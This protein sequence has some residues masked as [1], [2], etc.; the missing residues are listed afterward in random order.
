[1]D[2]DAEYVITPDASYAAANFGSSMARLGDFTGDNVDD[3]AIGVPSY[4]SR[5][6]RVIIVPGKVGGIGNITLPDTTNTITIDGDGTLTRGVFGYRVLGLGRFYTATGGTTLVVSAPGTSNGTNPSNE[7]RVYAFHGQT[8]SS[9]VILVGSADSAIVGPGKPARIGVA[10]TNLGSLFGSLPSVGIGN[11][12]DA[13]TVPGRTGTFYALSGTIGDEAAGPFVNRVVGTGVSGTGQVLFGG[14][15]SGRNRS[16][17]VIGSSTPD[18]GT[19]SINATNVAIVDGATISGSTVD[20]TTKAQV[21]VPLPAGWG[22]T[23]EA[24]G[25]IVP[26]INGDRVADFA[27]SNGF[28]VVPG[29]VVVYW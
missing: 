9:G 10:L 15:I 24:S 7:G 22:S 16:L 19:L 8:G 28:T 6:G 27:V 26:D 4:A 21:F 20:M 23:A 18:L 14:S 3:F 2:T 17:S 29:S 1:M 25:G 5:R 11:P 13:L 12:Y